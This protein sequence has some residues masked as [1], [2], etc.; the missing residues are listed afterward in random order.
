MAKALRGK[1]PNTEF[2]SGPYLHTFYTVKVHLGLTTGSR[3]LLKGKSMITQV[4]R[5]WSKRDA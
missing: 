1:R 5:K 3:K 4:Q 2:F